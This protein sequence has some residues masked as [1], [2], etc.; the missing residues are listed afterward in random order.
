MFKAMALV[1]AACAALWYFWI[2][3]SKLDEPM[4][5]AFYDQQ[6]HA[7]YS[8]DPEAL[9]KQNGKKVVVTQETRM[10]GQT[11]TVTMTREQACEGARKMFEF[12]DQVG[13]KAGGMLT[14]EY[15]YELHRVEIAPNRKSAEVEM[16][17]TLKMGESFMQFF[18]TSTEKLE[19][20]MRNVELVKADVKTRVQWKP[21]ALVE[22]EKY[23]QS[24]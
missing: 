10:S 24:Q 20:S 7:T 19:R 11:K 3:G 17:S 6:A 21:G 2:D 5:R 4:V 18:T 8:R 13:E 16:V 12:F 15:S 23:F 14:I 9:C 1:A 22:P